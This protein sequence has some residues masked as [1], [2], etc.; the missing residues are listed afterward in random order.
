MRSGK[1]FWTS[2]NVVGYLVG[3]SAPFLASA[4]STAS[5]AN[6]LPEV[7]VHAPLPLPAGER[8]RDSIPAPVQSADAA[9]LERSH[10]FSLGDFMNRRMGSVYVNDVQ[11]NPLQPDLNY[12][13]YTASP[14][15]GTPQGLAVYM[16]GIR[17]NQPFGDVVSWDLIPRGAIDS[18]VLVP[19]SSPLFGLNALGGA[20]SIRTK[21]GAEHSGSTAQG[22]YGSDARRSIELDHS[23]SASNGFNWFFSGNTFREDGWR[24]DSNSVS[25]QAFAKLGWRGERTKL[26]LT[27][28]LA[29]SELNGNGMQELRLLAQDYSSVYTKPDTTENE[30]ALV[31]LALERQ[32]A[33][34]I[35]LAANAH[36]RQLETSTLNGDINEGSLDQAV[37]Q[38]TDAERT[39]LAAAGYSGFPLSGETAANSPF[40]R[41]RCIANILTN[42]EPNERCSGLLNRTGT[43]Q[44]A[45][46]AAAQLSIDRPLFGGDNRV[47]FGVTLDSSRSE[48]EQS[49]QFGFLLPD[50]SVGTA[51]GPGAFADGTQE[52][53]DADDAGV[54]LVGHRRLWSFYAS[55]TW[56]IKEAWHLTLSGR[57]DRVTLTTRDLNTPG[58][59]AGSL[60]GDHTFSRFNPAF[61]LTATPFANVN[62]YGS[63]SQ[64]SRAPSIIELGCADPDNPCKLP[65]ALAGDPPLDQVVATT[66]EFGVRSSALATLSWH[67]G[68]FRTE[69]RDDILFIAD[70]QS[71]FGYF[72]NFGKTLRQGIEFGLSARVAKLS[73][74]A[75]YTYLDATYRSEEEVGGTGNSANDIALGGDRGF[76][77]VIE[78]EAGDRIPLIPQHTFK[79]FIEYAYSE[80]LS[81]AIDMLAVSSAFAR[82][83]ENNLHQP[84][85]LYYLGPGETPGYAVFNMSIEYR[86]FESLTAFAQITNLLDRKYYTGAQLGPMG[87]R[88]DGTFI[89][90]PFVAP[91]IDGERALVQS[92]FFSPGAPRAYSVG[93]KYRF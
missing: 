70:D 87:I 66:F 47:S 29:E 77:G 60:D 23:G 86:P 58:G 73:F 67:A 9:T 17:L 26:N 78:I 51:P 6:T 79:A 20:L 14:L 72:A 84:D 93:L 81:S 28:A 53:E 69:N 74:G 39:A 62:F 80:R 49:S 68:L 5:T 33:D 19:G 22:I 7:V 85:G 45:V 75:D 64:S 18:I 43:E 12:R 48:F 52:S 4:Q 56:E 50:R 55:D 65:N 82:G 57:F 35:S 31:A 16:D 3:T 46:G 90:R 11:N 36:Y 15:L 44:E 27:V 8:V 40:P 13:G 34:G 91:V 42:E 30:S 37:Y 61:G 89:A 63:I 21:D 38:P 71:G 83:N 76:E 2:L 92:T 59:G 24:D 10:S 54:E 1:R 88:A 25:D 41:W 32:I